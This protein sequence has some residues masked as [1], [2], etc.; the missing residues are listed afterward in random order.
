MF[1]LWNIWTSSLLR[2]WFDVLT[3]KLHSVCEPDLL[4]EHFEETHDS[5]SLN[6]WLVLSPIFLKIGYPCAICNL[7]VNLICNMRQ[8]KLNI[9][10]FNTVRTVW[11]HCSKCAIWFANSAAV[12]IHMIR[13]HM[14]IVLESLSN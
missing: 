9:R 11:L 6:Q 4:D 5:E 14:N 10:K 3:S 12:T 13:L 7:E 1:V 2:L 8:H